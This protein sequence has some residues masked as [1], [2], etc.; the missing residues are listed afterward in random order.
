MVSPIK[1]INSSFNMTCKIRFTA[2]QFYWLVL[3]SHRE[4]RHPLQGSDQHWGQT[5]TE[6]PHLRRRAGG[7]RLTEL[8]HGHCPLG[9]RKKHTHGKAA[10]ILFN[11][12]PYS[13]RARILFV[14]CF[15]HSAPHRAGVQQMNECTAVLRSEITCVWSS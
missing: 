10:I 14:H 13:T 11:H 6:G 5:F 8:L 15:A 1:V 12:L 2:V 7:V 4:G 9:S 3:H